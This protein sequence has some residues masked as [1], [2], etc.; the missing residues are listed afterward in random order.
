MSTVFQGLWRLAESLEDIPELEQR[1]ADPKLD[2]SRGR[3]YMVRLMYCEMLG[4]DASFA[5]IPALQ[6][7]SDPNLLTKKVRQTERATD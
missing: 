4:H 7:A 2:K 6:L 1:F 5:F 3:E